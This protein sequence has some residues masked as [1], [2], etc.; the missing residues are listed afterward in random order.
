MGRIYKRKNVWYIDV[1]I[2]GTRIRK[3][4]GKSKRVAELALKDAEVK[5][6]KDEFGLSNNDVPLDRLLAEFLDYSGTNHRESATKRY[7]AVI[8]HFRHFLDEKYHNIHFVSQIT[9]ALIESYKTFRRSEWVNPNGYPVESDDEVKDHTRKGARARTVNLEL[10]ALRAILNMAIEWGYTRQ[11][12]IVKVKRLKEDDRKPLR[13]L[14]KEECQKLLDAS[15]PD[16]YPACFTF[17]HTG[18]RK[19]ELENLQWADVDFDRRKI[20]IRRKKNWNPKTGE[21]EI[22]IGGSLLDV[23][24][25]LRKKSKDAGETDYVF[26]VKNSGHSH[27]RLRRELIKIAK[28]AGID[29]V[30]KLHT[31]RHTFASHLVMSGVDL[32]TVKKLMGHSDIQTTMVYAHLAPDHLAEAVDRLVFQALTSG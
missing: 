23:L 5:I 31:L 17:L 20:L 10:D 6:A 27:N 15:P 22:P 19:A 13:F 30:T 24:R 11:N 3:R 32:P 12:P 7:E 8:D 18:M 29:G 9:P 2:K 4:V 25:K 16:L 1:R 14:T 28:Q 26:K 21:R